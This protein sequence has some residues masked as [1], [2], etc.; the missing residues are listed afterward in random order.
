MS[1]VTPEQLGTLI[2][3]AVARNEGTYAKPTKVSATIGLS[4][5]GS[6]YEISL[7]WFKVENGLITDYGT[8]TFTVPQLFN[9][10][11]DGSVTLV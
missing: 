10:A 3:K 11:D 4:A 7:P 2:D 6:G 5:D 9:K 8:N 1:Y